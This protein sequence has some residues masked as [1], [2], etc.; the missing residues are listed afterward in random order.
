MRALMFWID[1]LLVDQGE[2]EASGSSQ[3]GGAGIRV[4][5]GERAIQPV[6]PSSNMIE[7]IPLSSSINLSRNCFATKP[8]LIILYLSGIHDRTSDEHSLIPHHSHSL[9]PESIERESKS[10]VEELLFILRPYV[11]ASKQVSLSI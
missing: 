8:C 7:A 1:W 5:R 3:S 4:M 6:F 2:S 10:R 9:V 11:F